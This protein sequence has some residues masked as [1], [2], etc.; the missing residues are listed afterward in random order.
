MNQ[1]NLVLKVLMAYVAGPSV[2]LTTTFLTN[3]IHLYFSI[4]ANETLVRHSDQKAQSGC[5]FCFEPFSG[6]YITSDKE[7]ICLYL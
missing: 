3:K 2:P 5:L 4:V 7:E 6:R 1:Q